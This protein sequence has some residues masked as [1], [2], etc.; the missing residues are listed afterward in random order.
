VPS[1][2]FHDRLWEERK[3]PTSG[4]FVEPAMRLLVCS[5]SSPAIVDEETSRLRPGG[6]G[7]LVPHLLSLFG[8]QGGE[9]FFADVGSRRSWPEQ[10]GRTGL[11]PVRVSPHDRRCHYEII[12]IDVLQRLFHYLHDTAFG[13]SFDDEFRSSWDTYRSVNHAFADALFDIA[14]RSSD[15][16]VI[17]VNDYHLLLVAGLARQNIASGRS[18]IVYSHGVPW[19]EPDYFSMLP[20]GIRHEILTSLLCCDAVV[21]H[22]SRWQD[23]FAACCTRDLDDAERLDDAVRYRD[24]ITRLVV[25]PFPLDSASVLEMQSGD[26]SRMWR[27]RFED[28]AGSRRILVRVD[29]LDL[30]K[31]HIRGFAAY[32]G[33]LRRRPRLVDDVWFLAVM[34]PPRYQSPLHRKYEAATRAAVQRIN[35]RHRRERSDPVLLLG[36][37]PSHE[38]RTRAIAALELASTVLVNPTYE[39]FSIVAKEAV[40]LGSASTVLLS[41][42]AGAYEQFP[43]ATTGLDP[44]DVV[45]TTDALEAAFAEETTVDLDE[46]AVWRERIRSETAAGWLRDVLAQVER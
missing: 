16:T 3:P 15:E 45:G 4:L 30:W 12:S 14:D 17:L 10:I 33:L 38:T 44:F 24:R 27:Q 26:S 2:G 31:N 8:A 37:D 19:C 25:A 32:E 40:F 5:N 6:A 13:P 23:A 43:D 35:E 46:R 28:L 34:T 42:N 1:N 39:G 29:R 41:T 36:P 11:H 9:W 22:S 18:T 21:F 20:I 7:G